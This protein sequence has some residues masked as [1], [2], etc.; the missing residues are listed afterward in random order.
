MLD[1]TPAL[2]L[3]GWAGVFDSRYPQNTMLTPAWDHVLGDAGYCVF[4]FFNVF[5]AVRVNCHIL[6]LWLYSPATSPLH[7]CSLQLSKLKSI[8][9]NAR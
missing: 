9:I 6:K 1:D 7:S 8:Y 3:G 4:I 2:V 5:C